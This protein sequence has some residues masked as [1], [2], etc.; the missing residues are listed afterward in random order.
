MEAL[1][2]KA[3]LSNDPLFEIQKCF[4]QDTQVSVW[5]QNGYKPIAKEVLMENAPGTRTTQMFSNSG[6]M[7]GHWTKERPVPPFFCKQRVILRIW[8]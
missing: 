3:R 5:Y 4:E 6:S 1:V 7:N 2:K 8:S